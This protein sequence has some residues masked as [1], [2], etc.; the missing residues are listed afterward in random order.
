MRRW[1]KCDVGGGV[2]RGAL[3]GICS[4]YGAVDEAAV[5][6]IGSMDVL[7]ELSV[8]KWKWWHSLGIV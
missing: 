3:D 1:I 7:V 8:W 5:V 6:D 2:I 4:P